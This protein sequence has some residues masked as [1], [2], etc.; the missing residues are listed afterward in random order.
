MFQNSLR[1][2]RLQTVDEDVIN[3][4]LVNILEAAKKPYMKQ[5]PERPQIERFER[6]NHKAGRFVNYSN[7]IVFFFFEEFSKIIE[8]VNETLMGRIH[9]KC[10]VFREATNRMNRI[11]A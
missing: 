3:Q 10:C 9:F 2:F 6:D 4:V 11:L 5:Q 8:A 1:G 7:L